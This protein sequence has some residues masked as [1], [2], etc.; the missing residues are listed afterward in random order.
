MTRRGDADPAEAR[1]YAAGLDTFTAGAL[2]P[3]GLDFQPPREG[4]AHVP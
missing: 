3:V 2:S 1:R 4:D